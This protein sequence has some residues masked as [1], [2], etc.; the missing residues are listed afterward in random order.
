MLPNKTLRSKLRVSDYDWMVLQQDPKYRGGGGN[1]GEE[2]KGR[3]TFR[4]GAAAGERERD[5]GECLR[6]ALRER[7]IDKGIKEVGV[8][9][10]GQG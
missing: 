1:E 3:N 8:G 9:G 7:W 2:A 6:K 10:D 4:R 5:R